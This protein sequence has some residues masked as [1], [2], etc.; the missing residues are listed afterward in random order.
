MSCSA[1]KRERGAVRALG[2][3]VEFRAPR[4]RERG[5]VRALG[6][7][8]E[9]RAP[10]ERERGAVRALGDG[11]EVEFRAPRERERG[12]RCGS[13][14]DKEDTSRGSMKMKGEKRH[15]VELGSNT[16]F[17][18]VQVTKCWT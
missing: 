9:F 10:R 14:E 11:V 4:E 1:R 5:A 12:G 18:E 8:V 15:R 2:D 3:C 17:G 7:G 13:E 16:L 6:D